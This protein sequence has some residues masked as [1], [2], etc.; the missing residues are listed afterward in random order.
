M[1][2][3]LPNLPTV[4]VDE[5]RAELIARRARAAIGKRRSLL[6]FVEPGVVALVTLAF[7][8]WIVMKLIE[9]FG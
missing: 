4:D 3:Q 5:A 8:G 1:T 9:V 6:R 2:D 7:S